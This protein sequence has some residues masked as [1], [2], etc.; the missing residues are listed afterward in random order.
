MDG[1]KIERTLRDIYQRL[2]ECYGP[3]HWW[4]ADNPFEVITGAILTQ[5]TAWSNVEKA[6]TNLKNAGSLTAA[7]LR[8]MPEER[9]A[10]LIHPSGYYNVKARKL[11]SFVQRLGDK[12]DDNLE[13]LFNRSTPDLREE[14]LDIYGIGEET[15]DSII[16]YAAGK[17]VFVIDAYIRRIVD[18]LGLSPAK[19]TYSDYQKLFTDNLPAD[20]PLFNEYHALIVRHGKEVCRKSP[21]CDR[22]RL[23]NTGKTAGQINTS[24]PCANEGK[25][26]DTARRKQT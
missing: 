25:P 7:A 14:L 15:A 20:A 11:K 13:K 4:P 26:R 19:K 9:L 6:I 23:N 24:Y 22:C 10:G 3:Q 5:S 1:K 2:Y 16:L 17:P 18:R 8:E 12:Y 21:L